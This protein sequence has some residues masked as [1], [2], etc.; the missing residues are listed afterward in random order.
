MPPIYSKPS[1]VMQQLE[2]EAL[3]EQCIE[4]MLEDEQRERQ[5]PHNGHNNHHF[6]TTSNG[7][8]GEFSLEEAVSRSTLNPL[9]AEFVP[10]GRPP[11][12]TTEEK[13]ESP[14]EASAE[15]VRAEEES[16]ASEEHSHSKTDESQPTEPPEVSAADIAPIE[17][18]PKEKKPE[19]KPELKKPAKQEPKK[20]PQVVKS[21]TKV[22]A[23]KKEVKAVK[24]EVKIEDKIEEITTAT[25]A[26]DSPKLQPSPAEEA[27]PAGP[28]P[29]NY[30][31]AAKAN[32]PKKPSTSPVTEKTPPPEVKKLSPE[33]TIKPKT[34]K[35]QKEKPI[36][37]KNSTK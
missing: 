21:D 33:V 20:K 37:R 5:R 27:L 14:P 12:P 4:A 3:M 36:Q 15:P 8:A 34:D 16:S 26:I 32:K 11:P 28:K 9:A 18:R 1:A 22:P 30:A 13:Q 7:S 31:A 29:I 10:S 6:P 25:A 35:K 24:S 2:E 17:K 19:K 23:K